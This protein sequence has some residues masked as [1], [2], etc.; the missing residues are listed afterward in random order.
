VCQVVYAKIRKCSIAAPAIRPLGS[1]GDRSHFFASEGGE[2][3][4]RQSPH[5]KLIARRVLDWHGHSFR[6][7][8]GTVI[9]TETVGS[10]RE[11]IRFVG[12]LLGE[13]IGEQS[14]AAIVALIEDIRRTAVRF[15][16]E[17]DQEARHELEAR[18]RELG[19][20]DCLVC[21]QAATLFAQLSNIVEDLHT[22][23]RERHRGSAAAAPAGSIEAALARLAAVGVGAAPIVRF[24]RTARVEP[25]LTAH[26]TEVR[27]KS[28]LDRQREIARLL[29]ERDRLDPTPAERRD[30]DDALRRALL[31]LWQSRLL[32]PARI[33]VADEI[34]N[35]LDHQRRTFLGQVP[36][37]YAE[38][39]DRLA[40]DLGAGNGALP[41]FLRIGCWIGSDRDGNPFVTADTLL[42]AAE[43]QSAVVFEHYL[44]ETHE[45]GAELSLCAQQ[46]RVDAALQ[47][48]ADR[49]PDTSPQRADEPYRRALVGIYARLAATAQHLGQRVARAPAAG[50]AEPYADSN[51]YLDDLDVLDGSL[52]CGNAGRIA[53]GRL[54]ALRRAVRVFG[55]HLAPLDLRQHSG[56][57]ERVV[58]ELLA[59]A[60]AAPA[61]ATLA[62]DE[63]LS[64]LAREVA[65]PRPLSSSHIHYSAEA[66]A[67]M[68]ILHTAAEVQRRFGA[69][70][71]ASCIVSKTGAASDLLEVALLLKEAGLLLPA[72]PVENGP[73]TPNA[74]RL[75]LD[76]VPLFE[77]IDDLRGCAA[78]M[79][80][81]LSLPEY[82]RLVDSR[83]GVQ[84][85]MLGYSDSNKDGGFLT[86]SWELYKA[87][88]DLVRVFAHHGVRLRLFHGRGGTVGR[89]GG[90]SHE[91]ILAQPAGSVAGQIRI[92]EQGE[93][94][95]SKYADPE[96][97]RR[98]LA[99]LVAAL[100]EASLLPPPD[101]ALESA[102]F[103]PLMEQLSTTAHS[104][105]RALVYE[106]PHFIHYFRQATPI[107]E[108]A[109]LNIGSRPAARVTSDRVED[110]RAIP[111]VFGWAQSRA[112]LPGWYGF[113]SAA[114][115]YLREHD[116]AGLEDLR[117]MHRDWPFF[118]SLLGNVDMV[119]AKTDIAIA[120]R[121]AA[122]VEDATLRH[123]V[124]HRVEE[125]FRRTRQALF[126]ITGQR[127][128]LESN[129]T[130]ARSIRNRL[131]Y[132]DPLNHLQLELLHRY[133]G[134][135]TDEVIQRALH[136]TVNGIAAVLRNSG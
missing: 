130:L 41:A 5:F 79:D 20:E 39:E 3:A 69:D 36:R 86:S 56:V 15:R 48:L 133:R 49:S 107:S 17:Q 88:H 13:T 117:R 19:N 85:V 106:T 91:A 132:L 135:R 113:G 44:S 84:E 96:V 32:R 8:L 121:Y 115:A 24:L 59:R 94:I 124:F 11:D 70:A 72:P 22:N 35:G 7:T 90:S 53:G 33:T 16:R 102:V 111:W 30:N 122:L 26:P 40:L 68:R 14:G 43:R 37:L 34:E 4:T 95:A 126:A 25:V 67:E 61:Y 18:L 105:Y 125:E 77:T 47:Q 28:I 98:T 21:V 10:L 104:A 51:A 9:D 1:A 78:V 6:C 65:S 128:C 82:R 93:V 134:G 27:R 118:R 62:E 123:A 92:T 76:I 74:P 12:R 81:L 112:L 31:T 42:Y 75:A 101:A 120:A 110:L 103:H 60:G 127:E 73:T 29:A 50:D 114:E 83:D 99:T 97:G 64:L 136:M 71:C 116:E 108:I 63:R 58:G 100:L 55:F 23:R 80:R 45:L 109:A 66:D 57:H 89:G 131:P 2:S 87:E 129:P 52:R 119:L 54:R 46:V 38:L